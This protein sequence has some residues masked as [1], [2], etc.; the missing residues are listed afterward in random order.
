[1]TQCTLYYT[2]NYSKVFPF[3]ISLWTAANMTNIQSTSLIRKTAL[4][5]RACATG[6]GARSD[7]HNYGRKEVKIYWE[8]FKSQFK[9]LLY[10]SVN[11]FVM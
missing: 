6:L 3:H 5:L 2:Y 11:A 9:Y 10:I 1:M 7:S 8:A 4:D